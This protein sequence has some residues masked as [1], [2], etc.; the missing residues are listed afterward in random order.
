MSENYQ[1]T[2]RLPEQSLPGENSADPGL[3]HNAGEDKTPQA[4]VPDGA[5]NALSDEKATAMQDDLRQAKSDALLE[6][7]RKDADSA[8]ESSAPQRPAEPAPVP[9][10]AIAVPAPESS[11]QAPEQPQQ[12]TVAAPTVVQPA[13]DVTVEP[14]PLPRQKAAGSRKRSRKALPVI[15]SI[16]ILAIVL[17]VLTPTVILPEIRRV[18][19]YNSAEEMLQSGMHDEACAAFSALGDY[20]DARIMALE[21]RY[22]KADYLSNLQN[23]E[24]A[25]AIWLEL[26]SYSDSAD[27]ARQAEYYWKDGDYQ[28]AISLMEDGQFPFAADIFASLGNYQDSIVLAENC[29]LLQLEA[30]YRAAEEALAACNYPVAIDRFKELGDYADSH[31]RYR[32][33]SYKYGCRLM[34]E[35]KYEHAL[36][37][38]SD[39]D[40]FE[41]AESM[42]IDAHYRYGSRLLDEEKYESAIC[43]LSQCPGYQN[44]DRKLLEAKYG[45]VKANMVRTN[46]TTQSYL[47][48]LVAENYPG[49]QR[50]YNEL[51]AWKVEIIA[52]NNSPYNSTVNQSTVSKYGPMCIHFKVT[53]GEP[54]ATINLVG[55][56][57]AP[58]G[59]SGNVYFNSCSD[60]DTM[61]ATFEYY[62]PAYG[63]TGTLS[64]RIYDSDGNLMASGSVRVTN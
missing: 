18:Q 39:A 51:Y 3:M 33:A 22:Q 37:R 14:A 8:A 7:T 46:T 52:Y 19:A 58:N 42:I 23:Y 28:F 62:Q 31:D 45:Y 49:A 35:H 55:N 25:I 10:T 12:L 53:G 40:G 44:A 24:E 36:R 63:A 34:E 56:L 4:P 27:R 41:D 26:G 6:N 9:E 30:E 16:L 61:Y 38:F 54:G 29:R 48:T 15:I 43:H 60:G 21:S 2:N 13:V 59:Q 1:E 47:K 50:L 11:S 64:L 32:E 20:K 5:G 57:I 17:A